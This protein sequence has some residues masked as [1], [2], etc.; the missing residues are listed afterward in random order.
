MKKRVVS[1]LLI[2]SAL[3]LF[4]LSVQAEQ[5]RMDFSAQILGSYNGFSDYLSGDTFSGYLLFDSDMPV[6]WGNDDS[7]AYEFE[8]FD[9]F[10]SSV[11]VDQWETSFDLIHM[12]LTHP[13]D[14][15]EGVNLSFATDH[16]SVGNQ[17]F[18]FGFSIYSFFDYGNQAV[19]D[20]TNGLPSGFDQTAISSRD[21]GGTIHLYPGSTWP[22]APV[23][24]T[25]LTLSTSSPSLPEFEA[26]VVDPDGNV[27]LGG[28]GLPDGAR[29]D[30]GDPDLVTGQT[31]VGYTTQGI[32]V[33][34]GGLHETENLYIGGDRESSDTYPYQSGPG[35]YIMTGGELITR[36]TDLGHH[37]VGEFTQSAGTHTTDSL[38]IGNI[39][40]HSSYSGVR[41]KGV[42]IYN[43]EE[44]MLD[45]LYAK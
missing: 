13:F 33:Q 2:C 6:S 10:P 25:E 20:I 7:T 14:P 30:E 9:A 19:F 12:E 42:G 1:L 32:F 45:S 40:T 17:S 15:E 5:I 24:F 4:P 11:Y 38:F 31:T 35:K 36:H 23:T 39:A 3:M 16:Q 34:T 41:A 27:L 21:V 26:P 43:L 22:N 18:S 29:M 37:T 44:G 28:A 8:S